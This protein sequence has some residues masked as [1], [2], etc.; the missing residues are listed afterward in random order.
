MYTARFGLISVD[1]S[2]MRLDAAPDIDS[3]SQRMSRYRRGQE[4]RANLLN[5]PTKLEANNRKRDAEV[6]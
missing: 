2:V 5:Q 1:G 3:Y 4:V 6:R